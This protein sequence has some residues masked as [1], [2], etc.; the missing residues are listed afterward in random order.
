MKVL[1]ECLECLI[2]YL[3]VYI[4]YLKKRGNFLYGDIIFNFYFREEC[5]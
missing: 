1:Y 3:E 5:Y 2:C 4:L